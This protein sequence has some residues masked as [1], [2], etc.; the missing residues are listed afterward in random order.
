MQPHGV[1]GRRSEQVA[2]TGL[3]W[4]A[5]MRSE[6]VAETKSE[7]VAGLNRNPQLV[8]HDVADTLEF[9][10]VLVVEGGRI[11]ENGVP[12]ALTTDLVEHMVGH[13]TRLVQERARH[14]HE[15]EDRLLAE[16]WQTRA[17][18]DRLLLMVA[19]VGR[20]W[21]RNIN[22]VSSASSPRATGKVSRPRVLRIIRKP[23]IQV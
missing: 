10:R 14:W 20:G 19:G 3:E 5:G 23:C 15:T 6:Q 12:R 2:G 11:V 7:W 8:C 4:V 13:R 9:D 22:S 21:P 18:L 1:A 17:K 16:Y